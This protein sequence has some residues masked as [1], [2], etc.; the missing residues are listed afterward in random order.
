MQ[1]RISAGSEVDGGGEVLSSLFRWLEQDD[2]LLGHTE[3]TLVSDSS[4][5]AQG[6]V[7]DLINVVITDG[8]GLGGLALSYAT[9]RQAHRSSAELKLERDGVTI[10]VSDASA[11]T[12]WRIAEALSEQNVVSPEPAQELP[13][14]P[15]AG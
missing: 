7:F 2:Q 5:D 1:V 3:I 11:E 14:E 12:V 15:K 10:Q 9:W 13:D 6:G 4:A 8:V